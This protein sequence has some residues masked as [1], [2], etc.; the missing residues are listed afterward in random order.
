MK[1]ATCKKLSN[2]RTVSSTFIQCSLRLGRSIHPY[3]HFTKEKRQ[4][5]RVAKATRY[6]MRLGRNLGRNVQDEQLHVQVHK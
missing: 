1:V 6:T 4:E 5:L 2:M 3:P